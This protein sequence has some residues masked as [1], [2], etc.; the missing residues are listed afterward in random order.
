MSITLCLIPQ[1][2]VGIVTQEYHGS[3]DYVTPV[4]YCSVGNVTPVYHDNVDNVTPFNY[5]SE[6]NVTP[7]Y[8]S[9]VDDFTPVYHD[10][11]DNVTPVL[12]SS[13]AELRTPTSRGRL[14]V[15]DVSHLPQVLV[16]V[17]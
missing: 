4:H 1:Y 14:V 12:H 16:T 7:V 13:V 10:S 3:V 5:G 8:H 11:V 6:G 15:I 2:G 17:Q 9:S